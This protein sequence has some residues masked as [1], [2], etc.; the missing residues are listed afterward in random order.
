[1]QR[2]QG[3]SKDYPRSTQGSS[4]FHWRFIEGPLK[5]YQ[6]ITKGSQKA[7]ERSLEDSLKVLLNLRNLRNLHK[8]F[9]CVES[10]HIFLHYSQRLKWK[11]QRSSWL[12][13][14]WWPRGRNGMDEKCCVPFFP[15]CVQQSMQGSF[16]LLSPL[17]DYIQASKEGKKTTGTK[18]EE[19]LLNFVMRLS[20]TRKGCWVSFQIRSFLNV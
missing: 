2:S 3:P 15:F 12:L 11:Q 18:A 20:H 13:F 6:M 10:S 16:Q 9:L 14:S 7:E 8:E 1:M 4:L 19:T 17:F 5:V